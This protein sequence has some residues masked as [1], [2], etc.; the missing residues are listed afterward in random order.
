MRLFYTA[1]ACSLAPHIVL[2]EIGH[3]FKLVNVSF[4][5]HQTEDGQD[6]L[7]I[8]PK[9]QVPFLITDEGLHLSEGTIISQ[10][11]AE[12]MQN[13]HLLPAFGD[14]KRYKVLEWMN[15]ISSELHK[16]YAPFFQ[17][18]FH[19]ASK[20]IFREKLLKQYAWIDQ[21]F[22]DSENVLGQGF[23]IADIYLFVVTRWA[24]F[25]NLDLSHLK[26]LQRFMHRMEQHPSVQKA[27]KNEGII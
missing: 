13:T 12:I 10:Y 5:N 24:S 1:G 9:G 26:V 22:A 18:G 19:E 8:N 14:L 15:Y 7:K 23:T 21:Q 2:Q 20:D 16:S 17:K 3:D 25:I 27:M 11:L 4:K 6:F